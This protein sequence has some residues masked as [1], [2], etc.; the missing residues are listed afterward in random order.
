MLVYRRVYIDT[1]YSIRLSTIDSPLRCSNALYLYLAAMCFGSFPK[2][3]SLFWKPK[4]IFKRNRIS[5]ISS[6]IFNM[7]HLSTQNPGSFPAFRGPWPGTSTSWPAGVLAWRGRLVAVD[8]G[9]RRAIHGRCAETDLYSRSEE[10]QQM[11]QCGLMA[12]GTTSQLFW[13]DVYLWFKQ[14]KDEMRLWDR[15]FILFEF[16]PGKGYEIRGF[17]YNVNWYTT[18]FDSNEVELVVFRVTR[19]MW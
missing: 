17:K 16:S 19:D 2:T 12:L 3:G 9:L 5:K 11:D 7:M 14:Q 8:V 4:Q 18:N 13:R 10:C 6:K 15:D 1:I